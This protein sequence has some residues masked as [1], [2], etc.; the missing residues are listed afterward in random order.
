MKVGEAI[1]FFKSKDWIEIN[2]DYR[3][4]VFSF[5]KKEKRIAFYTLQNAN[6][7]FIIVSTKKNTVNSKGKAYYPLSSEDLKAFF[8]AYDNQKMSFE[9]FYDKEI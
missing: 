7:D 6:N 8:I 9:N 1:I 5:V 2:I 3:S 4:G